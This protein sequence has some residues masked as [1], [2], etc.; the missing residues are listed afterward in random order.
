V[1]RKIIEAHGGTLD[2]ESKSGQGTT[3]SVRLP[4]QESVI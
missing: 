2:I 1:T 4:V 3:V